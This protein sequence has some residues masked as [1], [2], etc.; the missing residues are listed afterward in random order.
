MR[1][2]GKSSD[3]ESSSVLSYQRQRG[4]KRRAGCSFTLIACQTQTD[5]VE[6]A[7]ISPRPLKASV[8]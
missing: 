1:T 3:Y 4:A 8:V 6:A 5:K 2:G 7:I